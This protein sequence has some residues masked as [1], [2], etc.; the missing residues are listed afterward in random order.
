MSPNVSVN[1]PHRAGSTMTR[2]KVELTVLAVLVGLLWHLAL[3]I[4]TALP[5]TDLVATV[6]AL[7]HWAIGVVLPTQAASA[8][9]V[10]GNPAANWGPPVTVW[11][12]LTV[13]VIAAWIA[14]LFALKRRRTRRQ[15]GS[16]QYG[17]S[18]HRQL[19]QL[20]RGPQKARTVPATFWLE[21]KPIAER[22]ED[23]G[24]VY[25]PPRG[26]KSTM[27]VAAK[28]ALAE[29][30]VITTSTRP[31]VLRLT[32]GIRRQ[33]GTVYVADFDSLSAWPDK[34]RWDMVRG[35]E[36]ATVA[37][38]RAAAMVNAI[39]RSS[40]RSSA[41][42]YFDHGCIVILQALLH[43]AALVEG[44]MRDVLRWS[45]SFKDQEP[46]N[47]LRERSPEVKSWA[48]SLDE[49]CRENNPDTIGNTKTTLSKVTGPM[50]NERIMSLL[51]PT[52]EEP[53][54]DITTFAQSSNTL[55]ALCQ[56]STSAS[57]APIVTALVDSIVQSAIR[58]AGRTASG[59]L[60]TYLSLILDEAPNTCALPSIPSLMTAGGGSG[61]HTW[62]LAQAPSQLVTRWGKDGAET[63]FNGAA[64]KV[65]LGGMADQEF[66][67]RVST[68]IGREW[69]EHLSSSV[70]T[71]RHDEPTVNTSRSM[72]LD[73]KMPLEKIR[74]LPSGKA[75][76]LYRELEAVVDLVPWWDL[77]Q[78]DKFRASQ[79]WALEMEGI[80]RAGVG[81]VD[82]A[83][84]A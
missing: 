6:R 36:D 40:E 54:I 3:V 26:G 62:L 38:E 32:A 20:I 4:T 82:S 17:L 64:A 59:R 16:G 31:D 71:G 41:D 84:S 19:T 47:I 55:Y 74:K 65:I 67:E 27:I 80:G 60:D 76:L 13:L 28:V 21:G 25:G 22:A 68:L 24:V 45:E 69:V 52:E 48:G 50:K 39:P 33:T 9:A 37:A 66:L 15:G 23:T 12:T 34:V 56:P 30:A 46:A 77:P 8:V 57:T 2:T 78:A 83:E 10:G 11:A 53:G 42:D 18:S 61:V 51:C 35:C 44:T 7:L 70:G 43:A 79:Q 5:V 75:L 1:A 29:G 14:S 73:Q 49:W 72:Q 63:I 58:A 81:T